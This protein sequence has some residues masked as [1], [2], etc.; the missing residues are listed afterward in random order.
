M[1]NVNAC[2]RGLSN[3]LAKRRPHSRRVR[4]LAAIAVVLAACL[5]FPSR[6]RAFWLLGF[7][8]A[9][10]LPPATFGVIA[11]TGGQL[12]ETGDPAKTSFTPFLPHAGFRV[13]IAD[14]LDV[15]YRLTQVALPFS[16][17][18]PTL[19]GEIDVRYRLTPANSEWQARWSRGWRF[20]SWKYPA[21]QRR[22][23]APARI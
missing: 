16:S 3:A 12:S 22:R 19:G 10:T 23:G 2:S 8:S 13:G 17:V 6:G 11:G 1:P 7:S 14:G 5:A 4:T 18:G 15:G 20:P 9:D 21:Y